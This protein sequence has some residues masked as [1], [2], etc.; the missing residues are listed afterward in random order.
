MMRG[1]CS[2]SFST[3]TAIAAANSTLVRAA[4]RND[5]MGQKQA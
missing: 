1:R 3:I 4:P 5:A 2:G